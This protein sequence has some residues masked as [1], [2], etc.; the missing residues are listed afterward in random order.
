MQPTRRAVALLPRPGCGNGA[1][2]AVP[3]TPAAPPPPCSSAGDDACGTGCCNSATTAVARLG[4]RRSRPAR[5]LSRRRALGS[6]LPDWVKQQQPTSALIA[7]ERPT[8]ADAE[9]HESA[10]RATIPAPATPSWVIERP[11]R[12]S[13]CP[14]RRRHQ[15]TA[16]RAVAEPPFA[17]A[18]DAGRTGAARNRRAVDAGCTRAAA[19]ARNGNARTGL[20]RTAGTVLPALGAPGGWGRP[21]GGWN[22]AGLLGNSWGQ[23]LGNNWMPWGN[24]WGGNGWG[25]DGWM[26]WATAGATMAGC[27]LGR[28]RLERQ[29]QQ[30]L[31]D[32]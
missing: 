24:S 2:L 14:P 10:R 18:S 6:G 8:A 11:V 29:L 27:R 22:N 12:R 28:K 19:D 25:N 31:G 1:Q 16:M 17:A 7:P 30:R 32:G 20:C 4:Q 5:H 9:C 26:P 23:Q 13:L 15:Y 3:Q 21:Y